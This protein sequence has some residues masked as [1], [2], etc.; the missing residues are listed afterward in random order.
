MM[1]LIFLAS[2]GIGYFYLNTR[3]DQKKES[4]VTNNL[5]RIDNK[6]QNETIYTE[7]NMDEKVSPNA[8]I[9]RTV[10][11]EECGHE[12]TETEVAQSQYINLTEEEFKEKIEKEGYQ[13]GSFS[14]LDIIIYKQSD[15]ICPEHYVIGEENGFINIYKID[16]NGETKLYDVTNIYLEY[17]PD[18]EKEK[19]KNTIELLGREEL[20]LFLENLE[21]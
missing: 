2:I 6:T 11:Y 16:E 21:S 5:Y 13:L 14:S 3:N 18:E 19:I 9:T 4:K 7:S 12:I 15:G 8:H 1:S 10:F 17:L 20:N